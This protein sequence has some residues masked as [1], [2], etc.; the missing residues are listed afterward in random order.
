MALNAIGNVVVSWSFKIFQAKDPGSKSFYINAYK[1]TA[2]EMIV[3]VSV[4]LVPAL[5]VGQQ[6]RERNCFAVT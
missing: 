5:Q 3:R 1:I 4:S 6:R 2:L